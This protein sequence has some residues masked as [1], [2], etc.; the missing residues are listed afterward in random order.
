MRGG[1]RTCVCQFFPSAMGLGLNS[2]STCL[3]P[4]TPY[5]STC[6]PGYPGI[7]SPLVLASTCQDLHCFPQF[8]LLWREDS[9]YPRYPWER[10]SPEA[11][12]Q[13]Q[14]LLLP[15]IC[16]A[17][18]QRE[19]ATVGAH[20]YPRLIVPVSRSSGQH[21]QLPGCSAETLRSSSPSF[22]G[23]RQQ[24]SGRPQE[25][26]CGRDRKPRTFPQ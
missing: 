20:S 21:W 19:I 24:Q 17:L 23:S 15:R 16:S 14:A 6:S 5:V 4:A 2:G 9:R 26:A 25:G 7:H 13:L 10:I 1:Q 18:A 11:A 22:P 3:H 12:L 8:P